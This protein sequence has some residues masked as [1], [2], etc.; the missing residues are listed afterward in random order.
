MGSGIVETVARAGY[1]VVVREVTPDLLQRGLERIDAS[2]KRAV[3]RGKLDAPTRDVIRARIRG[4]TSLADLAGVDVVIEA[5]IE[6]MTE[7]PARPRQDGSPTS[8]SPTRLAVDPR[9]SRSPLPIV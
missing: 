1:E 7:G 4:T 5:V 2:M 8:S 6:K 9:D 3:D